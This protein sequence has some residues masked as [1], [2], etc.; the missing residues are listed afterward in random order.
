MIEGKEISYPKMSSP[1]SAAKQMSCVMLI[2]IFSSYIL[3]VEISAR[4]HIYQPS[5]SRLYL[6][7]YRNSRKEHVSVKNAYF[8]AVAPAAACI[9]A[10]P[11]GPG[12]FRP[13][14]DY[15]PVG[16]LH[17]G[18]EAEADAEAE[19]AADLRGKHLFSHKL[20]FNLKTL[21]IYIP[22]RQIPPQ[23]S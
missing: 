18:G 17:Q 8:P 4:Q 15:H 11:V 19:E 2:V 14:P 3:F 12:E 13:E 23:S 22:V 9:G 5:C 10:A 7:Y 6:Q 1:L 21:L 20:F 16:D